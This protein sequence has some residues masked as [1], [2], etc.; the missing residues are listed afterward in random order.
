VGSAWDNA[1]KWRATYI[2]VE[3]KKRFRDLVAGYGVGARIFFLG[4]LVRFDVAWR[5]DVSS[6]SKPIYYWS[7]GADF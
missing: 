2:D 3:G 6:V 1:N 5:Y 7:F 4:F